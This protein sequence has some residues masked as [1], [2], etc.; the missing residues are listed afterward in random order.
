MSHLPSS[1]SLSSTDPIL[2]Y[3][4]D[5]GGLPVSPHP[6][7]IEGVLRQVEAVAREGLDWIQLREKDLSGRACATLTGEA[8]RR[9]AKWHSAGT[10]TRILVND[11]LDVAITEHA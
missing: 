1:A 2:C 5:R 4:T 11:R 10:T 9:I 7:S 6:G 3:V 8:V